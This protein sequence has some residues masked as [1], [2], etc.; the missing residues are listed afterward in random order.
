VSDLPELPAATEVAVFRIVTE[1]VTNVVRHAGARRCR[2]TVAA[3][4]RCLRLEIADDGA[5]LADRPGTGNGLHT[6]RE[7]AEEMRGSL[8]LI[9]AGGTT[10]LAELPIGHPVVPEVARS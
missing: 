6:M 9:S 5:G 2:V 10:V 3:G 7:R 8:R 4:D 1:A